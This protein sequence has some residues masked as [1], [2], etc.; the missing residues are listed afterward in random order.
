MPI[1]CT[2]YQTCWI[3]NYVDVDPGP[4]RA[5]YKCG[6]MSYDKHKGTDFSIAHEGHINDNVPVLAAAPGKIIGIRDNMPD[7]NIR[8]TSREQ[9]KD[10]ECGNGVRIDHGDGWATQY[11]HMRKGSIQVKVDQNVSAGDRLGSVGISGLAEFPH[12]HLSVERNGD[13]IDPFRGV[14]VTDP[15][16]SCGVGQA[17]LWEPA[18][19][20]KLNY[21][22]PYIFNAGFS[23]KRPTE[24]EMS[25]GKLTATEF[26]ADAPMLIL[27]LQAAGTTKG[28]RV[29][30]IFSGPDG[31]QFAISKVDVDKT[32]IRSWYFVGKRKPAGG[33]PK[34]VYKGTLRTVRADGGK[35]PAS[36]SALDLEMTVK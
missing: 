8:K 21:S 14:A 2:P 30:L 33:W 9:V 11:C 34:G 17:P 36:R 1:D 15:N 20:E 4:G 29:E 18:V 31:R 28:D 6:A 5:D 27:W 22:A 23:D 10:K 32:K 12:L 7:V 24:V 16:Q 19:L 13:V 26:R 3:Q 35:L 25:E